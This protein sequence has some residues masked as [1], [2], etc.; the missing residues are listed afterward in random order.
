MNLLGPLANPAGVRRQVVGV[1]D[2]DRAALMAEALA[3]LGA[4]HAM[5]VHGRV[6]MDEISP[7]GVTDV[8]EVRDGAVTRWE[9]DPSTLGCAIADVSVLR[10]GE[11]SANAARI[12][13]LLGGQVDGD[14]AGRAALLLNAGAA[15]Y[16]AGLVGTYAEG[17]T[18]A[19][20]ALA[21]GAGLTA[22]ERLRRASAS[23]SG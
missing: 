20:A 15:I 1:A 13:R 22:L 21:S 9:I 14:P 12:E 4:E 6:G 3:R 10:G 19:A 11:P 23:T 18:R 8:W 17:V 2:R 16:V 5:V 7:Q